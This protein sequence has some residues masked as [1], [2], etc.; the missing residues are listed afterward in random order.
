MRF[1][2]SVVS[3]HCSTMS[4][5]ACGLQGVISDAQRHI[6]GLSAAEGRAD[7]I[8]EMADDR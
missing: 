4:G 8:W 3:D 6:E 5:T 1:S 2:R 7:E